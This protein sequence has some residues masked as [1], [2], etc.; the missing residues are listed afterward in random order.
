MVNYSSYLM[1][2]KM[3]LL[4]APWISWVVEIQPLAT[5]RMAST[6]RSAMTFMIFQIMQINLIWSMNRAEIEKVKMK[7][8]EKL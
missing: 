3:H 1:P 2:L 5:E 4:A 7:K 6:E 8:K